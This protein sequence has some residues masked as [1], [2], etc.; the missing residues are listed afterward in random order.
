MS[1]HLYR[2]HTVIGTFEFAQ[3]KGGWLTI[4]QEPARR[5]IKYQELLVGLDSV[6][7]SQDLSSGD[8]LP[9]HASQQGSDIVTCLAIV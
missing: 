2:V 1:M 3:V 9:L 7:L 5:E 4:E 8:V 6:W